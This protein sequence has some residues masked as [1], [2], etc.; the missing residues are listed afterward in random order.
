MPTQDVLDEVAETVNDRRV[1][2]MTDLVTVREPDAISYDISL[3]Y[4][5]SNSRATEATK[6]QDSIN[7]AIEEY[8]LWQKSKLGRDINPSE[9]I[10]RIMDAGASRVE[11]VSP[12]FKE[13]SKLQVALD[14]KTTITYGG[15]PN[16]Q[17][18]EC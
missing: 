12:V 13:V 10:C 15:C 11:I 14:A 18:S 1:R 6:I 2:P 16:D 4:W 9:L 7:R 5:I 17:H 3:T 8:K